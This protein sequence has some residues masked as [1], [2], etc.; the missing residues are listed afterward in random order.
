MHGQLITTV[1]IEYYDRM[2]VNADAPQREA[3]P[4]ANVRSPF[5]P[6]GQFHVV[7]NVP[8][9]CEHTTVA[10]DGRTLVFDYT[11]L[12]KVSD[13][14]NRRIQTRGNYATI[15]IGHS[16]DP[17]LVR[18]GKI[19]NP[20]AVGFAG[21]FRMGLLGFGPDQVWCILARMRF[22]LHAWAEAQT[23]PNR[24]PE[25]WLMPSYDEMFLDPIALLG[26]ETPRLDLGLLYSAMLH[27][28]GRG[29]PVLVEKYSAASAPSAGSV[30]VPSH[31][32]PTGGH[33]A[34]EHRTLEYQ[35]E[36]SMAGSTDEIVQAVVTGLEALDWVQWVKGQMQAEQA[37]A[38]MGSAP[39][40]DVMAPPGGAPPG[41]PDAS[42]AIPP[43][44]AAAPGL[45]AATPPAAGGAAPPAA[46]APPPPGDTPPADPNAPPPRPEGLAESPEKP[47]EEKRSDALKEKNEAGA[48]PPE[49]AAAPAPDAGGKSLDQF[50][51][52]LSQLISQFK[53]GDAAAAPP[54]APAAGGSP[55]SYAAEIPA[56]VKVEGGAAEKKPEAENYSLESMPGVLKGIVDSLAAEKLARTNLERRI[57]LN[58]LRDQ[59]FTINPAELFQRMDY[60]RMSDAEFDNQIKLISSVNGRAP[61]NTMV[62]TFADGSEQYAAGRPGSGSERA[63]TTDDHRKRAYQI[64]ETKA[65]AGEACDYGTILDQVK[66]GKI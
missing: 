42:G 34:N 65:L 19:K 24:S 26:A 30:S 35:G 12:K 31:L 7:E 9:F 37:P 22:F 14:C 33:H 15:I 27:V 63:K 50:L 62:Q 49:A 47:P 39:A 61:I 32:S 1:P 25:L 21:P 60:A 20:P 36:Q 46:A 64:A 44:A 5:E 43:G 28:D 53:G 59:G 38:A 55:E 23:Y 29:S 48:P 18:A 66:A 58:D 51:D 16:P 56:V 2:V 54:A 10:K 4:D 57:V 8:I 3:F 13:C 40:P 45:D 17:A 6:D 11:N 41:S 52:A